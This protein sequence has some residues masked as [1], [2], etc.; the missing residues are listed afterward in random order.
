M[1]GAERREIVLLM[2]IYQFVFVLSGESYSSSNG[3]LSAKT[4]TQ[5][6]SKL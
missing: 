3:V 5:F 2:S 4:A 6:K 1:G